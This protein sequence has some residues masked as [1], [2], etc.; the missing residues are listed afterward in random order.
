MRRFKF[1][2]RRHKFNKN[3]PP[4]LAGFHLT[5]RFLPLLRILNATLD[6]Q[7]GLHLGVWGVGFRV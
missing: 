1:T 2:V 4:L 5:L 7:L 3:Y 6:V